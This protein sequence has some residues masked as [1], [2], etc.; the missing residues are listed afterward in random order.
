VCQGGYLP[1]LYEDARSKK[2]NITAIY[3]MFYFPVKN[4]LSLNT[5]HSLDSIRPLTS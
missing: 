4:T 2:Y 1:E 5:A 3:H